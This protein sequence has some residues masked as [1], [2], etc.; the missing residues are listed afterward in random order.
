MSND[1]LVSN[2]TGSDLA[3]DNAGRGCT[4]CAPQDHQ[5]LEREQVE[6]QLALLGGK[7][8]ILMSTVLLPIALGA[9]WHAKSHGYPSPINE[10][11]WGAL[12]SPFAGAAWVKLK[13][14]LPWGRK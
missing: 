9:E 2:S 5:R 1:E 8:S 7:C 4:S 10:M 12:L 11:L 3:R 6:L 14:K 13:Q